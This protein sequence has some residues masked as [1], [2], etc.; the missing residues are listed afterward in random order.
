M[1]NINIFK[2]VG[3]VVIED[4]ASGALDNLEKKVGRTESKM[5]TFSRK[6]G[7]V[8]RKTESFGR[9]ITNKVTK[10]LLGFAAVIGGA[11]IAKGLQRLVGID[12]A[13]AKLQALG[14]D[15]ESVENIMT[16]ALDS[17][18][19][20]AFGL[21]EA[22]TTAANA[23]AAGV[24]PGEELTRY[25]TLAADA[26]AV[27]GVGMDDMGSIM[28]KVTT[29][30][31]AYNGELQQLSD[32][33]LPIY[34]WLA[35][36]AGV[37]ADAIFD[38]A[39]EGSISSEMLLNAIEKNIGGAAGIMGE[40][41]ITAAVDNMWAALGRLGAKFLD[42]GE[43]GEGFFSQLKPLI[44][45]LTDGLD[46]MGEAA[47]DAGKKLGEMF[48]NMVQ[49]IKDAKKWYDE[50]DPVAQA[51]LDKIVIFGGTGLLLLGPVLTIIGKIISAFGVIGTILGGISLASVGWALLIA[52]VV[53]G[54]IY[55]YN[56]F[57]WFRDGVQEI[58]QVVL[59]AVKPII[60]D[61]VEFFKEKIEYIVEWWDE[62]GEM[63]IEAFQNVFGFIVEVVKL[64]MDVVVPIVKD[65]MDSIKNLISSALDIVTGVIQF[66]SALFTGDME[67]LDAAILKILKGLFDFIVNL[68]EF[69]LIGQASDIITRFVK[70]FVDAVIDLGVKVYARF[71]EIVDGVKET[72]EKFVDAIKVILKVG[73]EKA[74]DAIIDPIVK[75]RDKILEIVD[76][77]KEAF[78][79]LKLSIPEIKLPKLPSPSITGR[80]S[81]SPPSVPKIKW[82]AEGGIFKDP[83]IFNTHEGL[84][85]VGEAG[86]EAI[87]PIEKLKGWIGEW[88]GDSGDSVGGVDR[89]ADALIKII[90]KTN[91]GG[92]PEGRYE[93]TFNITGDW[94][95]DNDQRQ[96]SV[97]EELS[98]EMDKHFRSRGEK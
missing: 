93:T 65:L 8:G 87:I 18:R 38:L 41:S 9:G 6:V 37:T 56:K 44:G 94:V 64:T 33:G 48:K 86:T 13:R 79:G 78:S 22:A 72:L 71:K 24:A 53:A 97:V 40:N 10:P 32:R 81:L 69:S 90:G 27:A 1:R 61:M 42:A 96:R 74:R 19:G 30:N 12:T 82:N 5:T 21:A 54:I 88:L 36:E 39:S 28:N 83:T 3:S 17:V 84:Q 46:G 26:A 51:T 63:I 95:V 7:D 92:T 14:H 62:H 67:E 23:V 50:L 16:S 25:L 57:E 4:N 20:T 77:I 66:F 76:K 29:S 15:A 43:D 31:K 47:E 80:L 52:G 89:M 75:A 58:F 55:A 91:N 2:L 11:A 98:R 70:S 45:S 85:G 59:E 60:D 35:E 73:F 68:F 34:Q 49:S